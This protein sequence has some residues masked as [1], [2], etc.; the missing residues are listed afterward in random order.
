LGAQTAVGTARREALQERIE[1]VASLELTTAFC[2]TAD[3]THEFACLECRCDFDAAV[4]RQERGRR[5]TCCPRCRSVL[6]ERL[7]TA[8]EA[9]VPPQI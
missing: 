1:V 9:V 5:I 7:V 4:C 8:C 6:I 2:R 3:A